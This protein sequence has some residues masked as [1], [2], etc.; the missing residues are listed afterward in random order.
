MYAI[1][2]YYD[3]N[4]PI[5][6]TSYS[7]ALPITLAL[8]EKKFEVLELL[9]YRNANLNDEHEPAIV[10]AARCCEA[11]TIERLVALGA[12]IDRTNSVGSNAYSAALYSERFDLLPRLARLGL[13]VDADGGAS[14]RQAV[15]ARQ[16][17]GIQFFVEN[18]VDM[19][20]V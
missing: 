14:F 6:L 4:E 18:G 20:V 7:E 10:T 1:R 13:R 8:V 16:R 2:S 11:S 15:F 9:L 12:Q 19:N 17:Q 3:I 5:L